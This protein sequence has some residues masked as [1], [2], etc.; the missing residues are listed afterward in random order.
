MLPFTPGI[1]SPV[2]MQ[3]APS[4]DAHSNFSDFCCVLQ[5][6]IPRSRNSSDDFS[7]GLKPYGVTCFSSR[8]WHP[9]R[10]VNIPSPSKMNYAPWIFY[11][12]PESLASQKG[13]SWLIFQASIFRGEKNVS[14]RFRVCFCLDSCCAWCFFHKAFRISERSHFQ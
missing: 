5:S 4:G 11:M 1:P 7:G 14:F 3:L 12:A 6:N 10:E 2:K 8:L 13:N 9:K